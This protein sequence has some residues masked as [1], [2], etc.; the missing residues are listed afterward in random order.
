MPSLETTTFYDLTSTSL[1]NRSSSSTTN[2]R[3]FQYSLGL[4][5]IVLQCFVWVFASVTTQFL[6]QNSDFDSPFF[7]SYAGM[8]LLVLFLPAMYVKDHYWGKK[9]VNHSCSC[10]SSDAILPSES[11]DTLDDDLAKATDYRQMAEAVIANSKKLSQ[12]KTWSHKKHLLAALNVAP[13]MFLADWAFN[14]ALADTTVASCTVLVST[15]GVIVYILAVAMGKERFHWLCLLGVSLAVVGTALTT[16]SDDSMNDGLDRARKLTGDLFSLLAALGYALYTVQVRLLC[17]KDEEKY[18]MG[19]LLGYAGLVC[20]VG[21]FPFFVYTLDHLHLNWFVVNI[22]VL[23]GLLDFVVTDYL[24]FR[25][26]VLTSATVSSVGMGL[27][28]PLAFLADWLMGK[29]QL[30]MTGPL[31][32]SISFLLVNLFGSNAEDTENVPA[33]EESSESSSSPPHYFEGTTVV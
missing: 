7:M 17:P 15:T 3:F 2:P 10:T 27:T 28:I 25:S 23:K 20:F 19:L 21:L 33:V 31:L 30:S 29:P 18:S 1:L 26:V 13:P 32:V 9:K 22:I 4:C 8:S 14:Q 11:F 5:F 24:L 16:T 12:N 6:Y